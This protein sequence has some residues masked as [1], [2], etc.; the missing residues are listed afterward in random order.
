MDATTVDG[1]AV[2]DPARLYRVNVVADSAAE[3][4]GRLTT[5]RVQFPRVLLAELNTHRVLTRSV[6]S[7]R[8]VPVGRRLA[9]VRDNPYLPQQ[10]LASAKGMQAGPPLEVYERGEAW[11]AW[12]LARDAAARQAERLSQL[13]VAK[14]EA[15]RLLEPFA[16]VKAVVTGTQWHN[17][18]ALRTHADAYPPFRLLARAMYLAYCRSVP[19]PLGRGE[20]HLPFITGADRAA[21]AEYCAGKPAAAGPVPVFPR[22]VPAPDWPTYHLCR[23][24]AARS[25]RVSYGRVDGTPTSYDHDDETWAK[26]VG[27]A[28]PWRPPARPAPDAAARPM[29]ASPLEHQACPDPGGA[30]GGNLGPGWL[31]FRKLFR[32]ERCDRFTPAAGDAAAWAEEVPADVFRADW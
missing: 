27:D 4:G 23:W 26:L 14:E 7:S 1:P 25:A 24:S 16:L 2:G 29:H 10:W 22:A 5:F 32:H 15:N 31:Q 11:A 3:W 20:W 9:A 28:D 19:T 6:E 12:L 17:F 13:G 18:F 8:A 30:W 21:A